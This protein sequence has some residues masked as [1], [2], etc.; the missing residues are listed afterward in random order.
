MKRTNNILKILSVAVLLAAIATCGF[1]ML[2]YTFGI[3]PMYLLAFIIATISGVW[4]V[5]FQVLKDR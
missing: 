2:V 1:E 3:V 5:L 4:V